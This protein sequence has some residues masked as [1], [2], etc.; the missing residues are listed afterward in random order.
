[1]DGGAARTRGNGA[2][3]RRQP[4]WIVLDRPSGAQHRLDLNALLPESLVELILEQNCLLV[5]ERRENQQLRSRCEALARRVAALEFLV[6]DPGHH[7]SPR[8]ACAA[9]QQAVP[10]L[11]ADVD[12]LHP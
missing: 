2:T 7:R 11:V 12:C 10:A 4:N 8:T 1:M 3:R 5:L 9:L 6:S